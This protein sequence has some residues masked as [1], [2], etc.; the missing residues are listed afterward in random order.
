[1]TVSVFDFVVEEL[2]IRDWI[3]AYISVLLAGMGS[4]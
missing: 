1:M 2:R 4:R 3:D